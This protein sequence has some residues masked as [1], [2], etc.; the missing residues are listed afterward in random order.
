MEGAAGSVIDRFIEVSKR[1]LEKQISELEGRCDR[2]KGGRAKVFEQAQTMA[3][4][5][6]IKMEL[7]DLEPVVLMD[8]KK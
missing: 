6:Q 4:I 2:E 5:V 7:R 3:Q 8:G 1:E